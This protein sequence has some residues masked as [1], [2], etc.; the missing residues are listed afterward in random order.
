MTAA[1]RRIVIPSRVSRR[2]ILRPLVSVCFLVL[3]GCVNLDDIA[4]LTK[5]ADSAQQILPAVVADI[6]A[7]CQRQNLLLNDIPSTERP[8]DLLPQD[9][10]PF[11]EVAEHLTKDQNVLIAYFDAL[12]KLASNT[13]L[14]C[15]QTVDSNVT[16]IE[17][18]PNLTKDTIAASSAAQEIAKVLADAVSH[19]YRA[20]KVK[21]IVLKTDDAVQELTSDLKMSIVVDYAGILSNENEA[22]DTYY[23]SPIA[24][25][26]Q[27][28]RLALIMVQRQYHGDTIVLESRRA[29]ATAYG[30]VMENLASLHA[31]LRAEAAKKA[32]LREIAQEIGPYVSNLKDAISKLQT[33]HK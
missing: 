16:T 3:A 4:H 29:A 24:A 32:S 14:S 22:L 17:K 21:S 31:K 30:K 26:G 23:K 19:S 12:G 33:E 1:R 28:E 11:Q 15:G 10:K 25:R 18:L 7:S 6:P 8:P 20:S 2:L 5:L 13:P 27:S 9:C